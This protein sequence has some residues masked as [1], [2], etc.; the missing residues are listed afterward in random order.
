[1]VPRSFGKNHQDQY[2]AKCGAFRSVSSNVFLG[3]P[4]N[5]KFSPI[6]NNFQKIHDLYLKKCSTHHWLTYH[7]SRQSAAI[8]WPI[9]TAKG[10]YPNCLNIR[11]FENIHSAEIIANLRK[12][13]AQGKI[14]VSLIFDYIKFCS[15]PRPLRDLLFELEL[16]SS[17]IIPELVEKL[18]TKIK[19]HKSITKPK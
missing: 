2:C 10:T 9:K 11:N 19:K 5:I 3:K 16:S 13:P 6:N 15:D 4:Y 7:Y 12:N 17:E 14:T 8:F 18:R 1:M